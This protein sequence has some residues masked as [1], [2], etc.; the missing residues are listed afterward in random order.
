MRHCVTLALCTALA[1]PPG[2]AHRQLTNQE[3]AVGVV[4]VA[5]VVGVL[6]LAGM[7]ADCDRAGQCPKPPDPSTP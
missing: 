5:M 6:V 2:C 1:L 4:G 7:A 3:V